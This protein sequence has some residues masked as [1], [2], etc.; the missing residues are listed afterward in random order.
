LALAL[1]PKLGFHGG[2]QVKVTIT[3]R[4]QVVA[5]DQVTD[6][7]ISTPFKNMAAQVGTTLEMVRC[8][9]HGQKATDVR[10]HVNAKGA[11]DLQYESCCP[12]LGAL[13]AKALG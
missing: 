3:Q 6:P 11:V 5:L 10:V 1:D 8:P 4:G 13:I 9:D 7:R 2:M 12:K